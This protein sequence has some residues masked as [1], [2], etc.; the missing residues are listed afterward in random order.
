MTK[1]GH[2]FVR[3]WGAEPGMTVSNPDRS[4]RTVVFLSHTA[5]TLRSILAVSETRIRINVRDLV[6]ESPVVDVATINEVEDAM[7]GANALLLATCNH[8][9]YPNTPASRS[10]ARA[11]EL[12]IQAGIPVFACV[13]DREHLTP[14]YLQQAHGN[15]RAI[16]T[17]GIQITQQESGFLSAWHFDLHG[18]PRGVTADM[19]SHYRR[20]QIHR[21]FPSNVSQLLDAIIKHA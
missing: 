16:I 19:H 7:S 12:A 4:V 6:K 15:L 11:V 20:E 14:A 18:L 2:A 17:F 9:K 10:E 13:T 8:S 5:V 1:K 3:Q 21:Y